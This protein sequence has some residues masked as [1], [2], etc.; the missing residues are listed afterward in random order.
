MSTTSEISVTWAQALAWRMQRHML[1][2]VGSASAADVV[3]RLGAV[4]SMDESLAELAV[5]AR[6]GASRPGELANAVAAG[7][8]I[9]SFLFRGAVH[10]LTPDDGAIYLALRSAGRQWETPSWVEHYGLTAAAWPDF[11]AAVRA[12]LGDSALTAAE[13][14]EALAAHRAYEHLRP[15]FEAGAVTL[16]KPLTWQGDVSLGPR[17]DGRLTLQRLDRNPAWRGVPDLD[18]AGPLAVIAYFRTYGPATVDHLHYWL[19]EGLSA[20]RKRINGWF[21]SLADQLIA[22]DVEG[23]V[24]YIPRDDVAALTAAVPSDEVRLLPG[25]DQW[26]MGPGTK[27]A[28]VTPAPLRDAMTHKANPVIQGGV[29]RGTWV[30]R[31]HELEVTWRVGQPPSHATMEREV[32]RMGRMLGDELQLRVIR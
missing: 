2:P 23:T 17:R 30:R 22:V 20:G 25:H 28:H 15:I 18:H 27:D 9:E 4:L 12:A 21:A 32:E 14:G 19:G 3:R 1:D 11:R 31:G 6:T 24:G 5:L 26:V 29:V 13:L 8:V 7:T 10:Y 16:I